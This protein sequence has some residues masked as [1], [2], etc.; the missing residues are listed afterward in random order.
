MVNYNFTCPVCNNA[1]S[2]VQAFRSSEIENF[3]YYGLVPLK[4]NESGKFSPDESKTF[5]II[6][7]ACKRCGHLA[8]F[9][10]KLFEETL[11]SGE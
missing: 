3:D 7:M 11:K 10:A 8:F 1:Y 4:V 9:H 5:P 6:V 2:K